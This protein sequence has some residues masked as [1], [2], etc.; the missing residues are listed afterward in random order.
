MEL[1]IKYFKYQK[2]K[3]NIQKQNYEA[4]ING[5][6][7]KIRHIIDK[8]EEWEPQLIILQEY[9][10]KINNNLEIIENNIQLSNL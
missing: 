1:N 7:I 9:I 4:I 10:N 6:K 5:L 3:L 2:T 8:K